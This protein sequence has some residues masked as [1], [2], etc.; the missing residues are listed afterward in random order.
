MKLHLFKQLILAFTLVWSCVNTAQAALITTEFSALTGNQGIVDVQLTLTSGETAEGFSLQFSE[1]LFSDLTI[2]FSPLSW[3]SLIFQPDSLLGAGL[4][5]N[6]NSAG[7]ISGSARI[8]FTYIG[9]DAL[10]ALNY[11]L[12]NA[13][14]QVISSGISTLVTKSL[15]ESSSLILILFG[16]FALALHRRSRIVRNYSHFA[17]SN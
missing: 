7:L 1:A 5:D 6:F 12:Y 10:P 4:F 17:V 3:D 2:I 15:P 8:A 14:F 16:L 9:S 13:D 11:E